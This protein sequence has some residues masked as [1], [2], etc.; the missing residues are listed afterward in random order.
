MRKPHPT[1]FGDRSRWKWAG[2]AVV[3]AAMAVTA[4][5]N[6]RTTVDAGPKSPDPT[7][8]EPGIHDLA[9]FPLSPRFS[10]ASVWTGE[11]L[12]V[13]G[14]Q[15]EDGREPS[16]RLVGDGAA[17]D[18]TTN[19]WTE[20]ADSPFPHGLYQP[21]GAWDGTEVIIVGTD[22]D[23]VVPL[24]T[25]GSPPPCSA[26]AALAWNPAKNSWRRLP[27]PPIPLERFSHEAIMGQSVAVGG[28][29]SAA[30]ST[31]DGGAMVWD[32]DGQSWSTVASPVNAASSS[33]TE[34]PTVGICADHV[35]STLIATTFSSWGGGAA[36]ASDMWV[37]DPESHRW[38][39]SVHSEVPI[40]MTPTCGAGHLVTTGSVPMADGAR[41]TEAGYLIDATTGAAEE[42]GRDSMEP[43]RPEL[44]QF[45][46]VGPWVLRSTMTIDGT[47]TGQSVPTTTATTTERADTTPSGAATPSTIATPVNVH[48]ARL[49]DRAGWEPL[50]FDSTVIG[51]PQGQFVG[52]GM[53]VLNLSNQGGPSMFWRA[54]AAL[55]P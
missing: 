14:G 29:G 54:P 30:F 5:S 35:R 20:V 33:S 21:I 32:R 23:A 19:T 27:V 41:F 9:S 22:C 42:L 10:A 24:T 3:V 55:A 1:A 46:I 52:S 17:L 34:P 39:P 48:T 25:D 8:N 11:Q 2:W 18:L 16:G 51:P 7:L 40:R 43:P 53:V 38:S 15:W 4:C 37:L 28:D 45:A 31:T 6:D 49:V 13:W 44:S 47:M 26:P 12:L 50:A 36:P